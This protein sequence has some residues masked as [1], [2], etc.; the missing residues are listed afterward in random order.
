MD[1][2][3]RVHKDNQMRLEVSDDGQYIFI[4]QNFPNVKLFDIKIW[5]SENLKSKTNGDVLKMSRHYDTIEKEKDRV[6]NVQLLSTCNF[7]RVEY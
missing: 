4:V 1:G 7:L 5:S 2:F 6:A 3:F